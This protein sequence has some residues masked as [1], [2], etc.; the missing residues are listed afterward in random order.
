VERKKN[1]KSFKPPDL[2]VGSIQ[3]PKSKIQ[4][5]KSND[6]DE[7]RQNFLFKTA[8]QR[9]NLVLTPSCVYKEGSASGVKSSYFPHF[10]S[11]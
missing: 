8:L 9:G 1:V 7:A 10:F 2:S 3:N 11:G 4:N 5:P 6:R